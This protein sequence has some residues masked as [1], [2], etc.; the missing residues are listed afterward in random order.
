MHRAPDTLET[1]RLSLRRIRPADREG[2]IAIRSHPE[3]AHYLG[4]AVERAEEKVD[5]FLAQCSKNWDERGVGPWAVTLR[6]SGELIGH[7]G[8]WYL[9]AF[10][11]TGIV[12]G[13]AR[14][15]WGQGLATEAARLDL[16]RVIALVTP[17][18]VSSRRVV[19][20]LGFR[21]VREAEHRGTLVILHE[22][23]R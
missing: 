8:F 21:E 11:A 7:A 1:A 5:W 6:E 3:V 4:H 22:I 13:Y 14:H 17:D 12:Y 23:V 19:A 2:L 9:E 18:N 20:K 15:S 10:E 16:E